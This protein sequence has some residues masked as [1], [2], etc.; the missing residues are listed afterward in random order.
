MPVCDLHATKRE[1]TWSSRFHFQSAKRELARVIMKME[2][3]LFQKKP[4][5]SCEEEDLAVTIEE[6]INAG[7]K[8]K[9]NKAPGQDDIPSQTVKAM[10]KEYPR[11]TRLSDGTSRAASQGRKATKAAVVVQTPVAFADGLQ[12]ARS[13]FRFGTYE[14]IQERRCLVTSFTVSAP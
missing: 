5:K 14:G 13:D 9:C 7:K 4:K 10:M 8:I 6:L 3:L 12:G 1:E 2:K 11:A